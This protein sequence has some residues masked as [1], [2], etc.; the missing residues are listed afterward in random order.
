MIIEGKK[1]LFDKGIVLTAI[2][3]F[4]IN[5]V[6][7]WDEMQLHPTYTSS[8]VLYFWINRHGLGGITILLFFLCG[9]PYG[10]QFCL[11]KS[12]GS[13]KYFLIRENYFRYAIS[14]IVV[15]VL[16]SVLASLGG[17]LLLFMFLA[18]KYTLYPDNQIFFEQ[19]VDEL[20]F[21]HLALQERP[22][23]F[24]LNI[25]PE[26]MMI[27]FLSTVS[28]VAATWTENKYVVIAS[29]IIV[30]YAWNYLTGSL[31]LPEI[32]WWTLKIL[33]GF[34][35]FEN[36]AANCFFTI[37]YYLAGIIM[38]GCIFFKRCKGDMENV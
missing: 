16:T 12:N 36:D 4:L 15:T 35:F 21:A 27:A 22:I 23:F 30:Y 10:I 3:I 33:D 34:Q 2:G 28:L 31:K 13:W 8:S 17:Y 26:V 38:I 19:M 32:F 14:K 37:G 7:L 20:P 5:L 6:N 11:E 9:I 29:P 24:L 18:C 1:A 25:I